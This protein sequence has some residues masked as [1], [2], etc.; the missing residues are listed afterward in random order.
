MSLSL[1]K[2]VHGKIIGSKH[3][4][5]ILQSDEVVEKQY[6]GTVVDGYQIFVYHQ[7]RRLHSYALIQWNV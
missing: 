1:K 4:L 5:K 7:T 3:D 2:M 6:F